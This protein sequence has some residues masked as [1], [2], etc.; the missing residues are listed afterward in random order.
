MK[1]KINFS[2]LP[3][4]NYFFNVFNKEGKIKENQKYIIQH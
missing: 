4:G 2:D 1:S 3:N